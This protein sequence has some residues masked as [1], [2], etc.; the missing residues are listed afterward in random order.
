MSE[1]DTNQVVDTAVQDAQAVDTEVV[2]SP[3]P[4]AEVN[5]P[6]T[7]VEEGDAPEAP[8]EPEEQKPEIP[9]ETPL[10]T[11]AERAKRF[12]E[13]RQE[14]K[15][16]RR[17][18]EQAVSQNYQPQPVEQ[19]VQHF[20]DQ[21]YTQFEA[22]MKADSE[23]RNQREQLQETR[24]QVAELNMRINTEAVQVMHDFPVFD[25]TSPEYDKDF[26]NKASAMYERAA[27]V[28]KD[29]KTGVIVATNLTPYEFY[30]NLAD[31][32][33]SGQ[34]QA[35]LKAQKAAEAQ[36]ARVDAQPSMRQETKF[37]DMSLSEQREYL[38]RKGH[39]IK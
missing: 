4:S 26:A 15:Q 11:E 7:P 29:P 24:T 10:E 16:H 38:R 39:D 6:E 36:M 25:P 28:M 18:V 9:E 31:L 35:Q 37:S 22:E 14:Q 3:E 2:D 5:T 34:T 27:G 12:Y 19:L 32:R 8:A 17:A 21:G 23:V 13:L 30:K 33:A 20:L 1:E